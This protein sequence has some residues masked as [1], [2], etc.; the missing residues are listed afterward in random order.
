MNVREPSQDFYKSYLTE[1]GYREKRFVQLGAK[2]GISEQRAL[3]SLNDGKVSP[4]SFRTTWW[5]CSYIFWIAL[6][7][8]NWAHGRFHWIFPSSTCTQKRVCRRRWYHWL[9]S[10]WGLNFSFLSDWLV[11]RCNMTT[12]PS[13]YWHGYLCLLWTRQ[14]RKNARLAK[15]RQFHHISSI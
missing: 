12:T 13:S 4:A 11:A 10:Q 6:K 7:V 14:L 1:G 3:R 2:E 9:I 8:P 5:N 15:L